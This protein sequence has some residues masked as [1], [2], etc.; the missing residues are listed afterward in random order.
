MKMIRTELGGIVVFVP[1]WTDLATREAVEREVQRRA[2]SELFEP[3]LCVVAAS[4]VRNSG[5]S[6]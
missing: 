1:D 4:A 2:D 6:R 3:A 5:A